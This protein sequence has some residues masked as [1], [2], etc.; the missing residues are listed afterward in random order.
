DHDRDQD[1]VA[2]A[3]HLADELA[4]RHA[5]RRLPVVAHRLH[6]RRRAGLQAELLGVG[7][8]DRAVVVVALLD[9]HRVG[10]V[11]RV[12]VAGRGRLHG[13]ASVI[14]A[15][16]ATA[17]ATGCGAGA[18]STGAAW[19]TGAGAGATTFCGIDT[20]GI[21]PP[22]PKPIRVDASSFLLAPLPA[23]PIGAVAPTP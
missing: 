8:R 7:A 21:D 4:L 6:H 12:D 2:A 14:G 9:R 15:G 17:T 19:S 20:P 3:L 10:L 18:T 16:A 11:R 1:E 13:V 5:G 23:A 22:N